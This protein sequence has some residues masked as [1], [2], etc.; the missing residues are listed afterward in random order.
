[1]PIV[2]R[3]K[4]NLLKINTISEQLRWLLYF[5]GNM[6]LETP[7]LQLEAGDR[8]RFKWK[9]LMPP[10]GAWISFNNRQYEIR[11]NDSTNAIETRPASCAYLDG[12]LIESNTT[13]LPDPTRP[14]SF[15]MVID[16]SITARIILGGIDRD[17]VTAC[18]V[19][20]FYDLEVVGKYAFPMNEGMGNVAQSILEPR[21]E[22]LIMNSQ[23]SSWERKRV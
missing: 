9:G 22:A 5:D 10:W 6:W 18:G 12:E 15:E 16:H 3:T 1:M 17:P 23:P 20:Y 19:G 21:I 2:E 14:H 8:V 4:A 7:E 11:H 13:P